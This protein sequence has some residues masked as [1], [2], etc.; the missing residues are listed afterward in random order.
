MIAG[1]EPP[2]NQTN[3]GSDEAGSEDEAHSSSGFTSFFTTTNPSGSNSNNTDGSSN[4][5]GNQ[6]KAQELAYAAND[7]SSDT[8]SLVVQARVKRKYKKEQSHRISSS[9]N[10]ARTSSD[11]SAGDATGSKPAACGESR[12]EERIACNLKRSTRYHNLNS[13]HTQQGGA[14]VEDIDD[15]AAVVAAAA[16]AGRQDA[17]DELAS[18]EKKRKR[19]AGATLEVGGEPVTTEEAL[20]LA[21]TAR[22]V[23]YCQ[24]CQFRQFLVLN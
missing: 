23:Y 9:D 5:S 7:T 24:L 16:S 18:R 22:Y 15:S 20:S 13:I 10:T 3:T 6:K 19:D 14:S 11:F 1:K 8:S 17:S 4:D 2:T 21:N 12:E